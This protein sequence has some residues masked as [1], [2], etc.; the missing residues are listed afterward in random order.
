[1]KSI[2]MGGIEIQDRDDLL[3]NIRERKE[4]I[5]D[6]NKNVSRV[7]RPELF[8]NVRHRKDNFQPIKQGLTRILN[9]KLNLFTKK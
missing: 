8:S 3:R 9:R 6:I 2:R 5:E 4:N 7:L 1:M